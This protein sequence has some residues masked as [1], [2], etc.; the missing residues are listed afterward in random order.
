MANEDSFGI[1]RNFLDFDPTMNE[2]DINFKWIGQF[3]KIVHKLTDRCR[4]LTDL[5][6]AKD[7]QYAD[8]V[9]SV[10]HA[11]DAMMKAQQDQI[12]RHLQSLN[13]LSNESQLNVAKC[14]R[15]I[16]VL[17]STEA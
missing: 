3:P 12:N 17:R 4:G 9:E 2:D 7:E 8:E 11:N 15:F 6:D 14:E 10:K 1:A 16:D 13:N 5:L